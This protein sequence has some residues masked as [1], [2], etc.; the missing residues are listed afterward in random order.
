MQILS[1][2]TE[3]PEQKSVEVGR[4][5]GDL[6]SPPGDFNAGSSFR[7]FDFSPDCGDG[8]LTG[9]QERTTQP[10]KQ[11]PNRN[12]QP[13]HQANLDVSLECNGDR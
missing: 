13:H 6:T 10:R 5:I 3:L 11:H 12:K 1:P 4:A 2:F 9:R 8:Q 7:T